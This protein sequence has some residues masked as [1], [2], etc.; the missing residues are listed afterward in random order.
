MRLALAE[1]EKARANGEVP[2]GAVLVRRGTVIAT[3]HNSPITAHDPTAHAEI[4]AL[5]AAAQHL[6]NYRLQD[7]ELFVTLEPCS[8]CAGAMLHARVK[9]LVYGAADAKTG[10]AGS[11]TDLFALPQL[12]HQTQVRGGV[13]SEDCARLLQDFFS[14]QRILQR[15][16]EAGRALREDAL[17]TPEKCFESLPALPAP[18]YY[19]NDLPSL[20]GL[21]L[22]YLD[23]GTIA[24][25]TTLVY[26]HGP[27][28]WCYAWLD[29][30]SGAAHGEYRVV[31]PDLIGFGKSDKPKKASFHTVA[32]H[33]KVLLE[34]FERLN[35]QGATLVGPTSMA[36]LMQQVQAGAPETVVQTRYSQTT[37]QD[38]YT[39]N[40]PYP[41]SGHQV[42]WRAFSSINFRPDHLTELTNEPCQNT[43]TSTH[44][45]AQCVTKPPS[46]AVWP[47]LK[48]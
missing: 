29:S 15:Q 38:A 8:M 46:N 9:R 3:G 41:D 10:A 22:H 40:A 6:G 2:V 32:W 36:T 42:A 44:L 47:A 14:Q 34:L 24:A 20:A 19:V 33:T 23:T 26:L 4:V 43:F 21:R 17:R 27:Q 37:I 5:R 12:N 18:S 13:L 39:R 30:I 45:L 28:D 16:A 1:A 7:C 25:G 31:C 48:S 35:L 11:V